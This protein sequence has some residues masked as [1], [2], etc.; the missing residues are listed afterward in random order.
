M[1]CGMW[2]IGLVVALVVPMG[3]ARAQS[4]TDVW[5]VSLSASGRQLSVGRPQNLTRR[6]GYDNQP[7]FTPDGRTVL[8][9]SI[10]EDAQ[11]DIWRVAVEGGAL[12]RV[13]HTTESEYSAT[14]TP[15]GAHFS[16]IRVEADSTQRLWR[17][18]LRM[19][20]PP[21]L[22]LQALRPVGYHLW[23][24]DHMIA[25]FV[26]GSPN[27]LVLV[28]A[29]TEQ[30]DTLS[31]DIGRAFARVPGRD[32]FTYLQLA[33]DSAA[34][35]TEVDVRTGV[36]S[37]VAPAPAGAEYH[38][39]TTS[40]AL[41][42]ASGPRILVWTDGRWDVLADLSAYGVKGIS[43]LALS[44]RGDRLAFVAEDGGAP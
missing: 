17:F 40:G 42:S 14:A 27:A 25:T 19:D 20:A 4:G 11:A 44:P 23:V 3:G 5:V 38:L 22:V 30:A 39:W 32:A 24:S 2:W 7:G 26:L 36:R 18:P 34:W 31:R 41:I 6:P 21:T 33:R 8:F 12:E 9:T 28:D 43:R 1:K 15:D 13:T 10:R 37:R 16:T 29:R 35:I